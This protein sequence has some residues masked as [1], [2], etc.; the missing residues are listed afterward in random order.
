MRQA[1]AGFDLAQALASVWAG[2]KDLASH[3]DD[4]PGQS[5][6]VDLGAHQVS[7]GASPTLTLTFDGVTFPPITVTYAITLAFTTVKLAVMGGYLA[8]AQPGDCTLSGGLSCG[9]IPLPPLKT[10]PFSLPLIWTF[11]PKLRLL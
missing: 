11:E 7:I 1:L 10:K 3:R 4:P 5:A 9:K 6:I 2:Y 8:R